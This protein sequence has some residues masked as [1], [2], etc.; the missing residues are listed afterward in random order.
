MIPRIIH[1]TWKDSRIPQRFQVFIDGWQKLQPDWEWRLWTDLDNIRFVEAHYP[2]FLEKYIS[3]PYDIQRVDFARYLILRTFGGVYVD[4]DLQCFRN[5]EPLL[6]N[7]ECVFS[8]EHES[9]ARCHDVPFIVSNAF[10]A[11]IPGHPIFD[12][13]LNDILNHVSTTTRPDR[14]ILESTGPLMLTRIFQE[15]PAYCGLKL[16][17][18]R[19]LFSLPLSTVDKVR[20]SD[21]NRLSSILSSDIYGLHW[22]DGT[23]WRKNR[24]T[25][26]FIQRVRS[27][28][29]SVF[30]FEFM[31]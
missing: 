21:L 9:H 25:S 29:L 4:M 28:L 12:L 14:L 8:L 31:P 16:L 1:Q 22:H 19:H 2:L 10:M 30:S 23:W 15:F 13:I 18:C 20:A 5:I 26:F 27:R 24:L 17:N 11:A 3:F 6:G 7:F